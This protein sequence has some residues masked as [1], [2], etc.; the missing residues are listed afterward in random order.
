MNKIILLIFVTLALVFCE[1]DLQMQNDKEIG[2]SS[3]QQR[4]EQE[5]QNL[6]Q[7]KSSLEALKNQQVQ[8]SQQ[9][10]IFYPSQLTSYNIQIQNLTDV[11]QNLKATER[12]ITQTTYAILQE[13]NS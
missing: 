7:Q 2:Q 4:L 6:E 12:D 11:L 3:Q 13:Q 10:G 9:I 8:L 5:K 1:N